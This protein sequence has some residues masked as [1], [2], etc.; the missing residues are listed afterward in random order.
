MSIAE[1]INRLLQRDIKLSLQT[2]PLQE[3]GSAGGNVQLRY[4]APKGAMTE[5]LL[6]EIRTHKNELIDFLSKAVAQSSSVELPLEKTVS[7]SAEPVP[8]SYAQQRIWF[9]DTLTGSKSGSKSGSSQQFNMFYAFRI[10][11]TLALTA[12]RRALHRI[13]ERHQVLHSH[14]RTEQGE[15]VQQIAGKWSLP[16]TELDW[17][18]FDD[19]TKQKE[20]N[21]LANKEAQ[22][23]FHLEA[24]LPIRLHLIALASEDYVAFLNLH[25]IAGDVWSIGV[26]LKELEQLYAAYSHEQ[27][28]PLPELAIQY[29]DY[30]HWQRESFSGEKQASLQ[31]HLD[32]WQTLLADAPPVHSLP[33]DKNRP[34][35]ADF[36]GSKHL[37]DFSPEL[38]ARIRDYC[39]A[40]DVTPYMLFQ[41]AFALVLGRY[42]NTNDV[43]L[44]TLGSGR[45]HAKLEPLIGFFINTQVSRIRFGENSNFETLLA[46]VKQQSLQGHKHQ[47]VPFDMLVD[48]LQPQRSQSHTPIFQI[49]F[50][51]VKGERSGANEK[52]KELGGF[53]LS[54]LQVE[55]LRFDTVN[56]AAKFDLELT[57]IDHQDHFQLQW[58]YAQSLFVEASIRRLN[59]SLE[60]LLT[61]VLENTEQGKLVA[62]NQLSVVTEQQQEWL[63]AQNDTKHPY[64]ADLTIHQWFEQQVQS[65]P[66]QIA[67][68]FE[69]QVFTYE[70]LNQQA[71]QFAHYLSSRV[72]SHA[73]ETAIS[74]ENLIGICLPR[75][76][77]MVVSMM[78]TLK[79][80]GAYVPM[81][82]EYPDARLLAIAEE[83]QPQCIVT[84]RELATR[85]QAAGIDCRYL[86]VDDVAFQAELQACSTS[87]L[88]ADFSNAENLAYVIFT[89]GSTGKPKGV[90]IEHQALVNRIHWMDCQYGCDANDVILQKTPFSFDVSVWEFFWPLVKGACLL[91]AK[92]E[93]HKEPDYLCQLIQQEQVS[94]MHF[95]PSMLAAML[96][97]DGFEQCTSL[98][99]VF[100][101][102]EALLA[103]QVMD[104]QHLMPACELHNL[105]GPTEAAIDV[106]YWDCAQYRPLEHISIPIG[107][108]IHNIGLYVLD[109]ALQ[110]V[111][112]GAVGQ[113]YIAGVGL[114]RGYLN[115][116]DLTHQ[117]FINHSLPSTNT[118]IRL[119][120]TGDLA[121]WSNEGELQ[122]LGRIDQ[123]VKIRGFR[124]ELGDIE[125]ALKTCDGIQDAVVLAVEPV[126][127]SVQLSQEKRLLACVVVDVA[128]MGSNVNDE[129]QKALKLAWDMALSKLLPE[130]M[131]PDAWAFVDGIPLSTN[132]KLDRKALLGTSAVLEAL[133]QGVQPD[134]FNAPETESE[135]LMTQLWASLLGKPESQ[136]SVTTDFFHLGGHSIL[137]V[138]LV[139]DIKQHFQLTI[140]VK[141]VLERQSIRKLCH[142]LDEL[143]DSERLK[144]DLK[145]ES[146]ESDNEDVLEI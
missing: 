136:I 13:I 79:A 116:P 22:K 125:Q 43:V 46:E 95:V 6:N 75:C 101:S 97:F 71:N 35:K 50:D 77:E 36:I 131:M 108:P 44:G 122:Y 88:S 113:L 94:K 93:G 140:T 118:P 5:D 84:T 92:P 67:L 14:I 41:T 103:Q 72:R 86:C 64:P 82:P 135:M 27:A 30:A 63:L 142:W 2:L 146:H 123:Q 57:V 115:R 19:A 76:P 70:Q 52:E 127:S 47:V 139:N 107:K 37:H 102:G 90:M 85:L 83:A 111:P 126:E 59:A 18:S 109:D 34:E 20:L 104:F 8:L 33:L 45:H 16:L 15:G 133:Q 69:Q 106:S 68:K 145:L 74:Q 48:K 73:D 124:I 65:S 53:S 128:S 130:Y 40:Q 137:A 24:E 117:S 60:W 134:E 55:P 21:S 56:A 39:V 81:E 28:D 54:G 9:I 32:Y 105:Y 42:G 114:A 89:S 143:A 78:A 120:K 138:R 129:Q 3:V 31:P 112:Q 25:H 12:F 80:G 91:L 29:A 61:Q 100:C 23:P 49:L 51:L 26:F 66:E 58:I 38:S 99:Q 11:G 98:R 87:N 121:R 62:V 110:L 17:Q 96:V 4:D 7:L 1:L 119:Y 10:T 144:A 141:D 132:G